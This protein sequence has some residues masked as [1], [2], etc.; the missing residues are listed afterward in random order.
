MQA[1][2]I[3]ALPEPEG[4]VPTDWP[5][6]DTALYVRASIVEQLP[7]PLTPLFAEL[8]DPSVSRTLPALMR[9]FLGAGVV[10]DGEITLP[11]INGYAYYRYDRALVARLT[12]S[13]LRALPKLGSVGPR[14]WREESHLRYRRIV[15]EQTAR[16][17]PE[18][19]DSELL[20]GVIT[21][22]DAGTG[23]YTAV[24]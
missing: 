15:A 24:R 4:P 6:P 7:D 23:Y 22:L 9:E 10:R 18:L 8:V 20:D 11:T 3:T 12:L 16:S 14:R 1:R 21:L 5:V 19:T 17:L 13:S 2:P